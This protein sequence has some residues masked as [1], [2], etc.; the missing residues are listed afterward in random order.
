LGSRDR[1]GGANVCQPRLQTFCSVKSSD[2]WQ[3]FLTPDEPHQFF[4]DGHDPDACRVIDFWAE[5]DE[6]LGL[7]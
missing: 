7:W 5:L 3:E 1:N 6:P 4:K 2:G